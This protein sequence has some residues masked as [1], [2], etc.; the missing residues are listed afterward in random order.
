VRFR[1]LPDE[2]Q[3]AIREDPVNAPV[4]S[5][6]A[7]IFEWYLKGRDRTAIHQFVEN[8]STKDNRTREEEVRKR[9]EDIV[10]KAL[11]DELAKV[12]LGHAV[13]MS[14]QFG[15][16]I[17]EELEVLV[18][19]H[20]N[21][22]TGRVSDKPWGITVGEAF[23]KPLDPGKTVNKARAEY[24]AAVSKKQADIRASEATAQATLNQANADK[25]SVILA[26][27]AE[28]D[29]LTQVAKGEKA[30]GM[31][32]VEV[33]EAYVTRVLKPASENETIAANFRTEREADAYEKNKTITTLLKGETPAV[34]PIG[35]TA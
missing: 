15:Q 30:A 3:Q 25:Q 4:T 10:A 11:Q 14:R 34:F 1:E 19:N 20:P 2:V 5:V 17:K 33:K 29:R 32:Q 6:V 13:K 27:E 35:K 21:P 18:G 28:R 23:L 7:A 24:A 8:V 26:G 22:D 12:T 9:A 16:L 31:T